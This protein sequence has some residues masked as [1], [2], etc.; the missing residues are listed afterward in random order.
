MCL[1]R[2]LFRDNGIG[3]IPVWIEHHE[4]HVCR[5]SW[6]LQSLRRLANDGSHG[7]FINA[8]LPE[9]ETKSRHIHHNSPITKIVRHPAPALHGCVNL[10]NPV[11]NRN[12]QRLARTSTDRAVSIQAVTPLESL[13]GQF[14]IIIKPRGLRYIEIGA[15]CYRQTGAQLLDI[16]TAGTRFQG[17][18]PDRK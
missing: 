12:R 6:R 4:F 16:A 14:Q 5:K 1:R 2:H 8:I 9:I 18:P 11:F 15:I 13:Y 3:N 7:Q 17:A 10:A